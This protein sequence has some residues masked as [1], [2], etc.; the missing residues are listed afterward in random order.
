MGGIKGRGWRADCAG[1]WP[2]SKRTFE[3]SENGATCERAERV[4]TAVV[5]C[6]M[7]P[8]VDISRS[9][10]SIRVQRATLLSVGTE[11]EIELNAPT[12]SMSVRIRVVRVQATG[13][14]RHEIAME[15]V[16]MS[17][18]DRVAVENLARHGKRRASGVFSS[19]EKREKLI[20]ALRMPDYYQTLGLTPCATEEEIHKA[21]RVLARKYH[22]DVCHEEG[23][24]QRFCAINDAH[25]TLGE[26]EKRAGYD[27][28][29]AMR[30][31]G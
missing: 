20:E 21:Y 27:A 25:D 9:G 23:A 7:G 2:W 16:G 31:A 3:T 24:Q 13:G 28:M 26:A 30:L 10:M 1:M 12:D 29:Y 14:G 5:S 15:F 17:E 4:Q 22:P 11:M 19:E 6:A 8:I 18:E